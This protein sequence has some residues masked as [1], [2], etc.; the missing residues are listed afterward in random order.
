MATQPSE[1]RER[2]IVLI[3]VTL[4]LVAVTAMA[5]TLARDARVEIAL[6]VERADDVKLRGL[7]DGAIERAMAEVR[8]EQDPGDSLFSPWRDDEANFAGMELGEGRV[9]LLLPSPDPGDGRELRYGVRDE[10]SKLDLNAATEQ[11]LLAL[12]GITQ[13]AVHGILDWRDEDDDQRDQG[14]EAGYYGTLDPPYQPKNGPFDSIEELLRVRGVD[15]QMLY[16]ED[17]NRNGLLDPGEDDGD[18]SF[19]PDDA[20]GEL[21]RG[22]IDYLTVF[23]RDLN[24][25]AD[26]SARLPWGSTEAQALSQALTSAGAS[27]Q[28]AQAIAE[29]R[30]RSNQVQGLGEIV[31]RS[32]QFDPAQVAILLDVVT[33]AEGDLLPGRI[34]VNTCP[35]ELL[36]G[37]EL[38]AEQVDAILE[39]RLQPDQDLSSPAWLLNVLEPA[40]FAT[41]VDRVT[42]RSDQFTVHAVALLNDRP[43]FRRVEVLIDR[44]F[45]PV[46]VLLWRDLTPLGFPLPEE[47]GEELP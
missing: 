14:A 44:N 19:P 23:S 42:T 45:V 39:A 4:I 43:R 17:H 18:G 35:R 21:D 2:G 30:Q 20:D 27:P 13:E 34:N 22:L 7:I 28:Y 5:L 8:A 3:L 1:G 33:V 24:R 37:L 25:R 11:Q 40:E 32:G 36:L 26:G 41:V 29:T 15:A 47:R 16:G 46:R 38:E 12:P 10:A 6:A 31:L 9:W